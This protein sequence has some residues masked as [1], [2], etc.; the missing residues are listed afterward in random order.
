MGTASLDSIDASVAEALVALEVGLL[1]NGSPRIEYCSS[2]GYVCC[3][4]KRPIYV[5]CAVKHH[6]LVAPA[7]QGGSLKRRMMICLDA[8]VALCWYVTY[9]EVNN[10]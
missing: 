9:I 4:L 1:G 7:E 2:Q 6:R 10:R 8:D 5:H 3:A